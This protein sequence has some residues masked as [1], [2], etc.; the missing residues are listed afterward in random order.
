[1][2]ACIDTAHKYADRSHGLVEPI[3]L[4]V[5]EGRAE[6]GITRPAKDLRLA[7]QPVAVFLLMVAGVI[8]IDKQIGRDNPIGHIVDLSDARPNRIAN[9][10]MPSRI[11]TIAIDHH[12]I[13]FEFRQSSD[14]LAAVRFGIDFSP[15]GMRYR[16][17]RDCPSIRLRQQN[18][19]IETL[20]ADH[21]GAIDAQ[22]ARQKSDIRVRFR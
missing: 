10:M 3:P 8:V 12:P 15:A 9:G 11:E 14:G 18:D 5:N 17:I 4:R 21:R 7:L 22:I 6:K 1:M 13:G 16:G 2:F 20:L 19:R